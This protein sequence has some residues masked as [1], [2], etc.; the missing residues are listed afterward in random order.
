MTAQADII[1][2][3]AEHDLTAVHILWVMVKCIEG[4][5]QNFPAYWLRNTNLI[6]LWS[7]MPK[8]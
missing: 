3:R 7:P 4:H 5:L 8:S 1:T 2:E 6:E